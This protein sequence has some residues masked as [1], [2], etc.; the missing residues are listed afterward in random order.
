MPRLTRD[1][2]Y[3]PFDSHK[4][5]SIAGRVTPRRLLTYVILPFGVLALFVVL[6]RRPSQPCFPIYESNTSYSHPDS[7]VTY[8]LFK[9]PGKPASPPSQI[10]SLP[11]KCLEPLF[12]QG[13]PCRLPNVPRIDFVWTWINGTDAIFSQAIEALA[14]D[15]RQEP[16]SIR[17][18]SRRLGKNNYR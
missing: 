3:V 13:T 11:D 2:T 14:E 6:S 9:R 5:R 15:L 16:L 10:V 17:L 4:S 7:S 12:E 18:F 8:R 1:R